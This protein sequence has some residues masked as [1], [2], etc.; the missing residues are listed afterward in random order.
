MA[1]KERAKTGKGEHVVADK[2]GLSGEE[3]KRVE[4]HGTEK[5]EVDADVNADGGDDA[6]R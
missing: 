6:R 2:A 3:A 4:K 1:A 5:N